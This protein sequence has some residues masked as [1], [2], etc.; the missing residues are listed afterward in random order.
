LRPRALAGYRIVE[1]IEEPT[2]S[3]KPRRSASAGVA[4]GLPPRKVRRPVRWVAVGFGT[5]ILTAAVALAWTRGAG[6]RAA[7]VENSLPGAPQCAAGDGRDAERET[8]GTAVGFVRSPAE[9]ARI[10]DQERKLTFL[11]HVSGNFD[12][13]GLT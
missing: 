8:F 2:P 3:P 12:D 7:P 6:D 5:F 1:V 13:P 4:K 9:A 10:A 11:L